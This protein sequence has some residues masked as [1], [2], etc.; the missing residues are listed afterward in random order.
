M[1]SDIK[2]KK[3]WSRSRG[4][5]R[6]QDKHIWVSAR[7][8]SQGWRDI[9]VRIWTCSPPVTNPIYHFYTCL[10]KTTNWPNRRLQVCPEVLKV[11]LKNQVPWI[12]GCQGVTPG[13]GRTWVDLVWDPTC[14]PVWFGQYVRTWPP[15][16]S[17]LLRKLSPDERTIFWFQSLSQGKVQHEPSTRTVECEEEHHIQTAVQGTDPPENSSS[18]QKK[19]SFLCFFTLSQDDRNK[20]RLDFLKTSIIRCC[21]NPFLGK[22]FLSFQTELFIDGEI[23]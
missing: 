15:G 14:A 21:L 6:Q 12:S 4:R 7:N 20:T 3:R 1:I 11:N 16:E 19:N 18:N 8:P 22:R 2:K 17:D 13:E 23:R 5:R 9:L 10:I